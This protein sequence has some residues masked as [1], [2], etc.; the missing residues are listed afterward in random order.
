A[1]LFLQAQQDVRLG[2][3]STR[4][5]FEYTMQ[6]PNLDELNEWAPKIL[7]KMQT[8]PELRDVATDQQTRGSTLTLTI[9]RDSASRYG[10]TPQLIDDT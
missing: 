10:I 7:A 6:D 5:Q 8:L 1:R 4:T 3:R 9:D 2:G